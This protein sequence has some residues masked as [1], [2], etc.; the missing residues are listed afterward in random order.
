VSLASRTPTI[1]ETL[2][3]VEVK[4]V[5]RAGRTDSVRFSGVRRKPFATWGHTI[6]KAALLH[7]VLRRTAS[8]VSP[9]CSRGYRGIRLLKS[10]G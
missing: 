6:S 3:T 7:E 9:D 5:N 2:R 8:I 1:R 10:F 4:L